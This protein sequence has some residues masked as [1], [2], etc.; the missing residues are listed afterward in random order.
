[1]NLEAGKTLEGRFR[2]VR[3]LGEGG[4]GAVWEAVHLVTLKSVALKVLKREGADATSA[5]RF[6]REARAA[7]AVKHPNVVKVHDVVHLDGALFMVM[8]LLDGESLE[9]LLEREPRLSI[10]RAARIL[11]PVVSAVRAAHAAGIVHRDLKP[12]NIF[13]CRTESADDVLVQVL[14]FGIAKLVPQDADAKPMDGK[15]TQTGA[16]LGTPYYMAPEQAFGEAIDPRA[17]IWALGV[18]VYEC[19]AGQRPFEGDSVG[20]LL[21]AIAKEDYVPLSE[22]DPSLPASLVDIVRRMIKTDRNERLA[23]LEPLYVELSRLASDTT[24]T[25]PPPTR[26]TIS[27]IPIAGAPVSVDA[28]GET[29]PSDAPVADVRPS[30]KPTVPPTSPTRLA[31]AAGALG[32][33]AV[34]VVATVIRMS[35]AVDDPGPGHAPAATQVST[36]AEPAALSASVAVTAE[37]LTLAPLPSSSAPGRGTAAPSAQLKAAVAAGKPSSASVAASMPAPP[38][39][40]PSAS[41]G[42]GGLYAKPPF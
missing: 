35:R 30:V 23:D 19:L 37:P 32:L 40:V 8:D 25:L 29:R 21:K 18:V 14:D 24:P 11:A 7:S 36:A 15:L 4:M 38:I 10:R 3:L 5:A 6:L 42:A 16:V 33:A 1:M 13:L 28:L 34:A 41:A 31:L 9:E 17:D 39:P 12:A 26:V 2:L 22:R 27:A 20:Q